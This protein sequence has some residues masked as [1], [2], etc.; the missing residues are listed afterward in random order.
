MSH[1]SNI[2]IM[3]SKRESDTCFLTE[4]CGMK[5]TDCGLTNR[6][7]RF[8]HG[9]FTRLP[10][11]IKGLCAAVGNSKGTLCVINITAR[12]ECLRDDWVKNNHCQS[13]YKDLENSNIQVHPG[14][15]ERG[16]LV[17][18]QNFADICTLSHNRT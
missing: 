1:S 2:I 10:D 12:T 7:H 18:K 11:H 6:S 8:Q 16:C 13:M 14:F 17:Y 15:K 4:R 5:P 9:G 3:L